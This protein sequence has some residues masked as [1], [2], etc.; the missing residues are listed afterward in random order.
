[1]T[2]PLA[3]KMYALT[4]VKVYYDFTTFEREII[5]TY[6]GICKYLP[7]IEIPIMLEKSTYS[8]N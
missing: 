3:T 5:S 1:M 6:S 8:N 2:S 4:Q 7:K